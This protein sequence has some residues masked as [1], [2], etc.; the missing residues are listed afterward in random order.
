MSKRDKIL[1]VVVTVVFGI[2]GYVLYTGLFKDQ[3]SVVTN[4]APDI[5]GNR[6]TIVD[7]LPYGSTLDVDPL[8]ERN[9]QLNIG[10]SSVFSYPTVTTGDVGVPVDQLLTKKQ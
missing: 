1:A 7:L 10:S 8:K 4:A 9:T 5:E 6:K 3:I 2:A